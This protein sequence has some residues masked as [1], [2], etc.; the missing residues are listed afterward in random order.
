MTWKKKQLKKYQK[1]DQDFCGSETILL[2]PDLSKVAF[3][4]GTSELFKLNKYNNVFGKPY[5][6]IK[7]FLQQMTHQYIFNLQLNV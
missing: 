5:S 1:F 6:Q 2:Y 3:V 7:L 4:S